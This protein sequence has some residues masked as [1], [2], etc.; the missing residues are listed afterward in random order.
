[1]TVGYRLSFKVVKSNKTKA[2]LAN[3]WPLVTIQVIAEPYKK[4]GAV[5]T[6]PVKESLVLQ[7]L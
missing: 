7:A 3:S 6:V 4:T 2:K 5:Y 1:V